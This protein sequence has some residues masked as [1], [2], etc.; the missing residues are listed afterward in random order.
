[1]K[2]TRVT[3]QVKLGNVMDVSF[4]VSMDKLN[5]FFE[6]GDNEFSDE[7]RNRTT[8][9]EE[10]LSEYYQI[11]QDNGKNT[12]RVICEPTG[13]YSNTYKAGSSQ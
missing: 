8:V 2:V 13:H 10:K 3:R 11:A 12:L 7:F 9:I 5:A 6:V 4:D 1:M